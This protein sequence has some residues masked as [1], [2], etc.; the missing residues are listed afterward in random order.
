MDVVELT[1]RPEDDRIKIGDTAVRGTVLLDRSHGNAP[2]GLD[3]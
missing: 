2:L 1:S 3:G